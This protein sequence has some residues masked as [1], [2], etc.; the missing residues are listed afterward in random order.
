LTKCAALLAVLVLASPS[1]ASQPSGYQPLKIIDFPTAGLYGRGEYGIDIDIYSDGGLLMGMGVGFANFLSFGITYGGIRVIGSGDPDMNP[2]PEVNIRARVFNENMVMPAIAIGFDSQGYG[3]YVDEEERYLV[4]SRGIYAVASKNWEL[5]GPLSLHGG[6]S[7]S[8]ENRT[9]HDPTLFFGFTKSLANVV[10]V[11]AEFDL[12]ANDNQGPATIVE[13]RGYLNAS[14]AW[15]LN[16]NFSLAL[17]VRD[18]ATTEKV[19]IEDARQWNRGLSISYR[20]RL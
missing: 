1:L 9:D 17:D 10:E 14:I 3:R 11:S 2:R 18:I 15:C 13:K 4:K 12:A 20:A 19:D 16:E 7:Y 8:L 6:L 5:A